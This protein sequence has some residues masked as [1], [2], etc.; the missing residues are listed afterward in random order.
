MGDVRSE[1]MHLLEGME[2]SVYAYQG[3]AGVM[4]RKL[5]LLFTLV[6]IIYIVESILEVKVSALDDLIRAMSAQRCF[7]KPPPPL[8]AD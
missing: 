4:D 6:D 3:A 8:D 5:R 1:Q 7:A 2:R